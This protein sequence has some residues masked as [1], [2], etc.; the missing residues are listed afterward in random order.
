M[1]RREDLNSRFFVV[2]FERQ[3]AR[4]LRSAE[5]LKGSNEWH[6]GVD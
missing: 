1:H 5:P 2:I 3:A 6:P 4:S